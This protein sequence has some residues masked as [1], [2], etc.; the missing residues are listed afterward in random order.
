MK[1]EDISIIC[2]LKTHDIKNE[3]GEPIDFKE[4]RFLFDIYRDES[5]NIVCMKAAQVGM[6]TCEVLRVLWLAAKRK[7]FRDILGGA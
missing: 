2:W 3:K 5:P 4:H 1:L 7:I 6:S